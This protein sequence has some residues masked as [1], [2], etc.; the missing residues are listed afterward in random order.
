M[1]LCSRRGHPS[2]PWDL[3]RKIFLQSKRLFACEVPLLK[4]NG[5]Y[6]PISWFQL[7]DSLNFLNLWMHNKFRRNFLMIAP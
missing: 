4:T 3:G 5:N 7:Q 1:Q 2:C 6:V